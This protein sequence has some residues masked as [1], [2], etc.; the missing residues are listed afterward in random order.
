MEANTP[1]TLA[2]RGILGLATLFGIGRIP[3]I[4]G[5]ASS[6]VSTPILFELTKFGWLPYAAGSLILCAISI[7]VC[8]RAESMIG[9]R[10]PHCIVLDEFVGMMFAVFP[11]C[12]WPPSAFSPA[13][14]AAGAFVLFRIFDIFK[15]IGISKLQSLPGGYG[16]V[17]DDVAAGIASA[18]LLAAAGYFSI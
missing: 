8:T 12:F 3:K 15:P 1:K 16:I 6:L 4:P 5:T 9:E 11:L 13:I 2:G 10:D 17:L 7:P 14:A 18:V